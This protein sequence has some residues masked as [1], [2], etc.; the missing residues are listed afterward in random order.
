MSVVTDVV[1]VTPDR[2]AGARF[3]EIFESFT[4]GRR[5]TPGVAVPVEDN[6]TKIS[7]TSVFHMGVNYL[8]W[9][10]AEAVRAENWPA[11]TVLYVYGEDDDAPR[12]TVW[13][14]GDQI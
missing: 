9:K 5:D 13:N 11:G 12:V 3:A 14:E 8:H 2:E 1:F 7:G 4:H 6:G 10:F